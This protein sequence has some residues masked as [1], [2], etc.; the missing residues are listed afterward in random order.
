MCIHVRFL[1]L[2]Y[3]KGLMV[4]RKGNGSLEDM[5]SDPVDVDVAL[6]RLAETEAD[7]ETK[8]SW[9]GCQK[10]MLRCLSRRALFHSVMNTPPQVKL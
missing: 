5:I 7:V 9:N 2:S 4:L 6:T 1:G 8:R 10:Y 3:K